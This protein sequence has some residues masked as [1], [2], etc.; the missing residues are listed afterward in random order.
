MSV[1]S[2]TAQGSFS[3][4]TPYINPDMFKNHA[5]AGVQVENLVP[6][7]TPAQQDAALFEAIDDACGWID[8]QAEQTFAATLDTW[9]GQVS[10]NRNGYAE[11]SPPITPAVGLTAFSIGPTPAQLG[12]LSSL[13]GCIVTPN[14]IQVPVFPLAMLTSS[15]GPIQFGG[16]PAPS[17]GAFCQ[18]TYVGGYPVTSLTADVPAGATSLPVADTTGIVAGKTWLT[19][20][21]LTARFRFLAGAVSTA[22]AGGI[23]TG[24]GTVGTGAVTVPRNISNGADYPVMIGAQPANLIAAAVFATRG[25]LKQKA[26][27]AVSATSA[28]SRS[29]SQGRQQ[30]GDDLE[31][32]WKIIAQLLNPVGGN[33]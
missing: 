9:A 27:G 16:V 33:E 10:I 8:S 7:G 25:M 3:R 6:K 29:P 19:V 4:V 22:D 26:G 2:V 1:V 23:G 15:Q 11:L 31:Q 13:A 21:A 5:R 14:Q 17:M 28:T 32:A 24:P 12:A 18:Y 30:A 20:Y